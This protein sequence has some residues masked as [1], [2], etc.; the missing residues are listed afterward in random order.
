MNSLRARVAA[1]DAAIRGEH[2]ATAIAV[3]AGMILLV[4]G[5]T[6]FLAHGSEVAAF[7]RFGLP[8]PEVTV[9]VTGL[10][11][12]AGGTLLALRRLV[13]PAAM[14]M[15]ATMVGAIAVSGIGAGDVLPS[16]TLAPALLAGLLYVLVRVTRRM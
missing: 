7:R 14:A 5:L 13:V 6:K 10:L 8:S 12:A 3:G 2:A 9:T 4:A 16:L 15:A 1:S 11:E